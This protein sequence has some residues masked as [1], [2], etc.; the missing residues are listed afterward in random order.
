MGNF[1]G[2]M[3]PADNKI[4]PKKSVGGP[5]TMEQDVSIARGLF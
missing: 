3:I 1:F 2:V 5:T 4:I